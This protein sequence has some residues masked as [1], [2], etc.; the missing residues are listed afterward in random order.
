[1]VEE[2]WKSLFPIGTVFKSPLLLSGSSSSVKN[3]I[4]PLVFNP[5]PT[6]LTR[7]FS[8]PSLLPSLSP[9]SILNLRRFLL[10][11]S[12]VVPSTSSSVAS[13][14]GE[15]QSC[16][17]AAS[18]LR[19]NRLQ[20]LPCP[21]SSSVVVFFPTGPN[22]DHVGFLVVSGNASGL[23]VQSDYDNDVFSVETELN[24]QIFGIAVNPALG[25]GFDGDSSVGIGF[26]LAYTMY[27]VEWFVVENH[28]IDSSHRPRVSLVNMGSKVFK[29]CSVVHACWNPHLFE[30]S[31]VLL[32]DGSL[33]LFDMEPLLKAK[34]FN[35]NANLKGIRLKV[36]WDGLDCSKKVKW[37]S[38][39]FSWHPR[40][41]IVARS[42]AI[43]LV[44]LREDECSISCLLKIET[45][46]SYSLAEKGQFLAFSKAG[47]DGFYFCI[48]SS[49]LLLLCDIRK[50]M[51][52]V[53]QWTHSLDDPS[54][55]NVFSLSE[56][57]SSPG[58]SMYKLASESGYCIVLGSFWSCEFN[59]FCY[60]PSPP[61]LDQSVSSR[62][63]K[64]FQSLYAWERPSNFILSGRE[65]PCSSCLLRQES[66][67][68]AIPEWVEWQQK[69]EIVLGFS[70]LDNNLS[71]PFTGQNEYGSFTLI[72]LMSSGVLEAQTYQASWNSLKQIDEV[73]KKSLS[74][75]DYLL[76]GQLVDD[77]Y[78]F[79]RRYTYFNFDYLMGYLNDN[80]DKV[81]D[82]FMRKYSKDS[83][84]ERS[85]TLEVHEV[86]CEKLKACGFDRLRSTPALAVVFNDITLPSSIQEIAFKK[87]WAS[88]PMELLHFAFSSYSEFL[89][90]KN[91]VSLE[92]LSVPSLNQLPPFM[93]RDSSSRSNKWSHKVRRTENIVGPVLPLPILL[94]LHE[95][96]NGCSKLEEE[97]AGKFSLEA[98]FR[99]Q[100]DEIRS[101]AGEMAASPFDPKVDDG[102]AVSLADDQEYVSAE[103]QKPKN[104]VSYHPFAFNS[105]TLDNTQGNSTNHAD[106][107]DSLIFK[108]KGGKDASSEKS[109]NN[110]SGELYNDLCPVELEFN[111]PLV[112]FGPKEL[113]AYGLLKRQLLKWE[114]GFDAYKE[115]R[116]KI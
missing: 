75:D 56:L 85:L 94:I 36:S 41:L 23:D 112:N 37:L 95:F 79:S 104:F 92:F 52:P 58:N 19:H 113:K 9:P 28:A 1:M 21:N 67:K 47:S 98:E 90:N 73:H 40:I 22:S 8:T 83:L 55:V 86:L 84:C 70:I 66:L 110:A 91:A 105:H 11:S 17:D 2:E 107:F 38:C 29:T 10:T 61:A 44:D 18:T 106:V 15:Q 48:A 65:C 81:L 115:F 25:L 101:A 60:G 77:K 49:H 33:F 69:K 53:L 39:E 3:S 16:G 63:S 68:D 43:F 6:S 97:E 42:D 50:P 31:V 80:L 96:R 108:L 89:E 12:P 5:V 74:L 35:A 24:Y 4:G 100:Y 45:F 30:E 20:F 116:S 99:E 7:L 111:A 88:L 87:L 13:L 64:Y 103:S 114:D 76:Y 71:L 102:P 14:F 72:R 59:I 57:R 109:E 34:N 82:S 32:E 26:L 27:S 78:R 62:S 51:S 54:Y 46:S 93:L